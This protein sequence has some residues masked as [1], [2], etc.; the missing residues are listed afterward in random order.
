MKPVVALMLFLMTEA[1]AASVS[2]QW[3]AEDPAAALAWANGIVERDRTPL[4]MFA[5]QQMASSGEFELWGGLTVWADQAAFSILGSNQMEVSFRLSVADSQGMPAELLL[6]GN[7]PFVP[8]DPPR[9]GTEAGQ[10]PQWETPYS[11]RG[12]FDL[13][14]AEWDV[15]AQN[16]SGKEFVLSLAGSDGV[17]NPVVFQALVVPEPV[18]VAFAASGVGLLCF[19]RRRSLRQG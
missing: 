11:Y 19:R 14:D 16:A 9:R 8:P 5:T 2:V 17:F 18:S 4:S 6:E 12:R 1:A 10:A 15:F 13:T 3:I 7:L